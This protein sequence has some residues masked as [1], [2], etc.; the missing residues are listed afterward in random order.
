[1]TANYHNFHNFGLFVILSLK[2]QNVGTFIIIFIISACFKNEFWKRFLLLFGSNS[3]KV[4]VLFNMNY[5]KTVYYYLVKT[6]WKCQLLHFIDALCGK[7]GRYHLDISIMYLSHNMV[8]L[9]MLVSRKVRQQTKHLSRWSDFFFI[10]VLC[11]APLVILHLIFLISPEY[12]SFR[13]HSNPFILTM[14]VA[15]EDSLCPI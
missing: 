12:A 5:E 13:S 7:E 10:H 11:M 2:N 9:R 14:Y 4:S 15:S 6:H 3:M 1:M 8:L